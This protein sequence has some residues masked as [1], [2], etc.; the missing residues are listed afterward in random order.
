LFIGPFDQNLMWDEKG[1]NG[2]SRFLS[3]VWDLCSAPYDSV[4]ASQDAAMQVLLQK[5][6]KKVGDDIAEM[7][8]NTAVSSLMILVNELADVVRARQVSVAGWR[9]VTDALILLLAPMAVFQ[10]EELWHRRGGAGSVHQQAW[11][12]YD[13]ALAVDRMVSI[14]VQINSKLRDRLEVPADASEEDVRSAAERAPRVAEA[15]Q[16]KQIVKV[17]YASG[18]L[19]NFIVQSNAT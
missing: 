14:A 18:R 15:L 2:V 3:R 19:I 4:D 12:A 11:P 17:F 8:F 16:H 9:Q 10:A 7:R 6:I 1:I 5:T 13:P